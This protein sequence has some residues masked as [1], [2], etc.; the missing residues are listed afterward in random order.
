MFSSLAT[1]VHLLST[2]SLNHA[3]TSSETI[4]TFS[5]LKTD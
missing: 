1:D 3:L 5:F 4:A 2:C